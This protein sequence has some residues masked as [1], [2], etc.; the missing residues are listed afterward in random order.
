MPPLS[1][2]ETSEQANEGRRLQ[3]ASG[4]PKQLRIHDGLS[5]GCLTAIDVSSR[6]AV[7]GGFRAKDHERK[8]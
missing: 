2:M 3:A 5:P 8:G 7:F 6:R 1:L 4:A